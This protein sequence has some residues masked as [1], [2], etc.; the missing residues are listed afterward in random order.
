MVEMALADYERPIVTAV[1]STFLTARAAARHMI[2]QGSGVILMFGGD[3][4]R[5]PIR[6]YDIGGF[7]VALTTVEAM[8]RQLAAEL[9]TA[10]I[11]AVT[12]DT[13]GIAESLPDDLEGRD[14]ILDMLVA[15]TM[16]KRTATFDDV[17]NVAVFAASDQA[18]TI[19]AASISI[20]CGAVAD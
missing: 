17:A 8:R 11:R 15:P 9:G 6:D 20:T 16:L 19:T 2:E 4:G 10:G 3:G 14:E 5:D 7:Q 13:G 18:R 1:R 12:L